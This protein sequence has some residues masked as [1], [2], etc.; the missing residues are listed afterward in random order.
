VPPPELAGLEGGAVRAIDAGSLGIWTTAHEAPPAASLE[1]IRTHN[2]VVQA[3][4]VDGVT[5]VPVRYG[6][7]LPGEDEARARVLEEEARW[8][9]LL[10]WFAGRAEYG[11]RVEVSAGEQDVQESPAES[12]TGYMAAL[13]TKM[14]RAA[15]RRSEG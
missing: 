6:Q 1:T 7:W 11:V 13:A 5:P 15:A 4:M 9:Q 10:E 14:A 2:E 8:A 3:A 12:G